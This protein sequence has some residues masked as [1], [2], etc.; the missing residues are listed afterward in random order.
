M[1]ESGTGG[2]STTYRSKTPNT[3]P[4][5]RRPDVV[6]GPLGERI[7]KF[8]ERYPKAGELYITSGMDG[9]HGARSHH[10]GLSYMGS[11]T[12]ALD[13][14]AG[15]PPDDAKMRD[16]AKWLYDNY[17]GA[18]VELIHSTP[19]EDD[20]GF[21][22]KN[23]RKDPGGGIYG[24]PQAIGHFDHVHWATSADLLTYLEQA[25]ERPL[26]AV[27]A[28]PF[29]PTAVSAA[30]G[31]PAALVGIANTSPVWGWDASNH[32]W[33]PD[34]GPMDLV[35]AQ[36][37]GISF[38]THK[39]TEGGDWQDPHYRE[40]LERARGAGIPVLGAYHYLWPEPPSNIEDQVNFWMDCV[41]TQTPWWKDVPW[42]W[43]IDAEVASVPRAP[44][45]EEIGRAVQAVKHRMA[46]QGTTGYVIVYAPRWVYGNDLGAGYDIWN[47]DYR[48]S[49]S[50]RPF[51]DQYQGDYAAG[52]SIMSGRRP[53]ILQFASDGR[54]GRQNTCDVDK[55]DADLHTLIRLC[56]RDPARIGT[57]ATVP[58]T[59]TEKV[60]RF[61]HA[62][63]PQ[64]TV[65]DCGPAAAQVV[66]DARGVH[67]T[68]AALISQIGTTE[69]GTN[70]VQDIEPVLNR[71]LPD[72]RYT[73]VEM[74][75]DPPTQQ[76]RDTLW[77][78]ICHS[79]DAG[80]GV[81]MN[82]DSPPNNDP[83][84]V[85]GSQTPAY[86]AR[87]HI[88]HYVA[89]M[90]YD[91]NPTLPAV[92]I[93]DSG[94]SPFEYW[95]SFDQLAT[96]I[97]PKAYAFAVAPV[98]PAPA[99][100][101][102]PLQA[103]AVPAAVRAAV[104]A[105]VRAWPDLAET[106]A[107]PDLAET[108]SRAMWGSV[109]LERYRQLLPAV[110]AA[111]QRCGCTSI[112]R[113]AMWMA[114]IGHESSGL[115]YMQEQGGD[116]YFSR[117]YDNRPDLGN[118]Q[119]GDGARFHGRGPIQVTG[120]LHYTALSLWAYKQGLVASPT[121]FVDDPDQLASDQY[122]FVGVVWYWTVERPQLN[123]LC[124]AGDLEDAT[125]AINGGLN[126]LD[127]R[128]NRYNSA[129]AMGQELLA[130][131]T[132]VAVPAAISP[133]A[134]AAER[135]AMTYAQRLEDSIIGVDL[136]NAIAGVSGAWPLK[137]RDAESR[138]PRVFSDG[139]T[140]DYNEVQRELMEFA[141]AW[142][143][144]H[145]QP[146]SVLPGAAVSSG[147]TTGADEPLNTPDAPT[148]RKATPRTV[149]RRGTK[150]TPD[151]TAAVSTEATTGADEPADTPD[152]PT[153]RKSRPRTARAQG[154]KITPDPA[155]RPARKPRSAKT[156]GGK[157][158]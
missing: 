49:G 137:T 76:Q 75:N 77:A 47:S 123:S 51:K 125:R 74:P 20:Q 32:D 130:L 40:A 133:A 148:A 113:I 1:V 17:A 118:T 128:R 11:P 63:I 150:T 102:L 12:A 78:N 83:V 27:V 147:A 97:P 34:R 18:T 9:D 142:R 99:P 58:A 152:A 139:I 26:G 85:K 92:F 115:L 111:L 65:W 141:I 82:W 73:S 31:E 5:A 43:Q 149:Q 15:E 71:L 37:D 156:N 104:P 62:I 103:A 94:F 54:V 158:S 57:P 36:R 13:I 2:T 8:L 119:P 153:P 79:I 151:P 89:C 60:L 88:W 38:F 124:D 56:G 72:A 96:L 21:Y 100:P 67:V 19:F 35:A 106:L 4:I 70:R 80:Y 81:V 95:I 33:N 42:I 127:D 55:F 157:G 110:T 29:T 61:D 50:P 112:D 59:P 143:R 14:G 91:P 117:N 16:F 66:L 86:P 10:Y 87:E 138:Y 121:F 129:L 30:P 109:P 107:W 120:R 145:H 114:Q 144:A 28:P 140:R 64:D 44:S 154:T 122:G 53:R 155:A 41:D 146:T 84:G 48:G 69:N 23:Q 90:G 68:E 116:A 126:G 135:P 131:S 134:I 46:T 45:A 93:A 39:A 24:G 132:G 101:P 7:A 52:W 98:A 6:L 3:K 108:L 105:A 136:G 25:A 22:V